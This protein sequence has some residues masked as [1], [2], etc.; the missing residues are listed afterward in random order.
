MFFPFFYDPVFMISGIIVLPAILFAMYAQ[1]RVQGAFERYSRIPARSGLTGAEVARNLLDRY[2]VHDVRVGVAGGWFGD[3]YD[4]R[5]K[6]L[7]LSE[8]VY[9][10]TSLAALGV[11][12]HETGHALQHAQGYRALAL[13]SGLVPVAFGSNLAM[14]LALF[15]FLFHTPTLILGGI[16]LYA[17]FVA[18]T[19]V[20]LP[21]EFNA[22]SRA[23]RLLQDTGFVA[24]DE[25]PHVRKVL[26][27]AAMTYLAAAA[28]AIATLLRLVFLF[29]LASRDD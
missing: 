18:F 27:A 14:P 16:I 11:A 25:L 22:S 29:A 3:H 4:P 1:F 23:I 2:G 20:T 19:L 12:A 10:G 6:Q 24:F 7:N 17:A 28:V 5:K 26:N 15:G 8:R 9:H 13:R 21:V